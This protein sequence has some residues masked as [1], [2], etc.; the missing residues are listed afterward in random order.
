LAGEASGHYYF[1]LAGYSAEMGTLPAILL[2]N[3]MAR[4][5]KKLSQL[6]DG[7]SK[8]CHSGELNMKSGNAEKIFARVR[9]TY[10]DGTLSLLDGVKIE[11]P[12]WWFSLRASNTEPLI[13]LNLEAKTSNMMEEKK[14]E[15][16]RL[17]TVDE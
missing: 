2:M 4:T 1:S 15:L 8:Y 7:V 14:E 12:E 13:R 11:Y 9:S 10:A 6:V 3:L 17:I 16:L 5:D